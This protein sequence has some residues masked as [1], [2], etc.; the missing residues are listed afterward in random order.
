M[1]LLE[2]NEQLCVCY[3]T[4][5]DLNWWP[6]DLGKINLVPPLNKHPT[7]YTKSEIISLGACS[8]IKCNSHIYST[9]KENKCEIVRTT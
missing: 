3:I 5:I 9:S 6:V 4:K 8:R 7:S 2:L 1:P